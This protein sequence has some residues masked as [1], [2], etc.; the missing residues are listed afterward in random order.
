MAWCFV[1]LLFLGTIPAQATTVERFTLEDLTV[2]AAS[3]FEG[4]VTSTESH[5]DAR[6]RVILTTTTLQITDGLKGS[7]SGSVQ[8]TTIGGRVGNSVLHVAG[9]AAFRPGETAIVFT[10]RSGSHTTVLGL[11]QGKFALVN[12][13]A[14]NTVAE[15]AFSDG[16]SG[17]RQK[18]P[19]DALK[20]QILRILSSK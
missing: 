7:S 5:W 8:I 1:L 12:G 14:E 15:L 9:M 17:T 13:V 20:S 2:R 10:E 18:M 19:V 11:S 3:I 4:T 6:R 16:R